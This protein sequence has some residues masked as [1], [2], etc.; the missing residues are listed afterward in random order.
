MVAN[1]GFKICS[2]MAGIYEGD[3]VVYMYATVF[4]WL[5]FD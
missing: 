4:C 5:G 3:L 2:I 1:S